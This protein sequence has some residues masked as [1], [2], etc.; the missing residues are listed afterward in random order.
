MGDA[1]TFEEIAKTPSLTSAALT[2]ML[3]DLA[4]QH[5]EYCRQG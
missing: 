3:A 2:V 1:P 4:S 5:A